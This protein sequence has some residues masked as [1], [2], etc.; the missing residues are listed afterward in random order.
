M[1]TRWRSYPHCKLYVYGFCFT[2]VRPGCAWGNLQARGKKIKGN[3]NW[4]LE[5]MIAHAGLF[6]RG[7]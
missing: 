1:K 7:L 5:R 2:V 3:L 6:D 4:V